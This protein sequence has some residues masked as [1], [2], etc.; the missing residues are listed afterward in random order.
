MS[1]EM[2]TPDPLNAIATALGFELTRFGDGEAKISVTI[3]KEHLNKGGVAFGGVHSSMLDA[4][5]G[6]ALVSS[7]RVEEW[8]ATGNLT[9]NYLEPGFVGSELVASGRI[10]RRGRTAAHL[11]GEIVDKHGKLDAT[12]SGVWIVW[13]RKPDK[14]PGPDARA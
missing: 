14:L 3:T 2:S 1:Y 8:C 6:A 13:E 5:M 4:A 12:A 11:S 9:V 7:L 10:V